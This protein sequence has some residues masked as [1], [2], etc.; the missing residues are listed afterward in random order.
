MR[1]PRS[2]DVVIPVFNGA[3]TIRACLA[4]VM[5]GQDSFV[6]KI[7]V[8]DDGSTDN[9]LEV[10]NEF[11][12]PLLI[13]VPTRNAGVAAARNRGVELCCSE[14]V[15]FLDADD[16]W[17]P[18]K[19]S[20]QLEVAEMYGVDFICTSASD[21]VDIPSGIFDVSSLARGNFV[22]T[23]SVLVRRSLLM[24]FFPV[25]NVRMVFAEDYLAWLKC[26][27]LGKAYFMSQKF[28]DYAISEH[29]RY[30]L[31][32]VLKAL[33]DVNVE[34]FHF[35]KNKDIGLPKRLV[36]SIWLV[37]GSSRSFLSILRR[38]ARAKVSAIF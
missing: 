4:S 20:A 18:T 30:R 22:A 35:T 15:A 1:R 6:N 21:C 5:S 8:V 12:C 14:W 32:V 10:L 36:F 3:Q 25:F 34:F 9:T 23:S 24:E 2:V 38:F 13:V 19:L 11:L 7:I 37:L 31:R 26:V 16:V 28:V 17:L 29:P 27:M 33:V